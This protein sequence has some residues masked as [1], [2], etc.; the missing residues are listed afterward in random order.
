VSARRFAQRVLAQ[1]LVRTGCWNLMLKTWAR[2][3][4]PLILTYHRVLEKWGPALDYSQPGMIVTARTFDSQLS[5][6]CE[7]FDVVPLS[8]LLDDGDPKRGACRP[9]CVITFDDGWRDNYELAFPILRKHRAPATIFV[10]TDFIGT[11]RVFWHTELIYLLLHGNLMKHVRDGAGLTPY[12]QGVRDRLRRWAGPP[13]ASGTG[14]TD[15]VVEA[16]K[17]TC[18]EAA[19]DRLIEA[20][21]KAAGLRRPLFPGR[22][23]FLDWDQ[24]REMASHDVEI[25]SHG[26]SHRILTRLPRH[27]AT[28]E[29]V[30]SKAEIEYRL[31]RDVRHF[32]CPNEYADDALIASAARGGYRTVCANRGGDGAAAGGLRVLR[33]AGMNE[34]VSSDGRSSAEAVLGWHLLRAPKSRPA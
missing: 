7:H 23:F 33:R 8:A 18:D 1:G 21:A 16:V 14:D 4:T 31:G 19:I 2:R 13:G 10:T 11:E 9:R 34:G 20:L 22:R 17:A 28:Q 6:L 12:P 25:G 32:A 29:L 26:T 5:F 3:G 27:E 30:R 24:I 15:A